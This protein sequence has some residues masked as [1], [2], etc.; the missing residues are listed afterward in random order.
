MSD[1]YEPAAVDRV[2]PPAE[3][4]R[5]GSGVIILARHGEPALSRKIKL[6]ARAYD[7]WWAAYEAGG[8]LP[9][10]TPPQ[11]LLDAAQAADVIFSSTRPRAI[12][13]A[14]AVTAGRPFRREPDLVEAPLPAPRTP[15]T[16]RLGPRAWGVIARLL[17][18]LGHSGGQ[19]SR[20]H[21]WVRAKAVADR[22]EGEAEGGRTVLV[23]AHGFFNGMVGVE[24][25]RRGW[26][27]IRDRGF[28]YW[29]TRRFERS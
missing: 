16:L 26:R 13:T 9:G 15:T 23:L 28:K 4:T 20:R 17:W 7:R 25:T 3:S 18:Y 29:S 19:E 24:L 1:A 27:C 12:Q 21:A 6:D 22:L 10:Q 5:S 11:E 14:E 2:P 8:I